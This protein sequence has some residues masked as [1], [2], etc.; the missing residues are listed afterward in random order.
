[1]EWTSF[2]TYGDAPADAFENFCNHLF[3]NYIYRNHPK[4]SKFR[5]VNG[6]GGD[7]GVEAYAQLT[8]GNISAVQSKWFPN[9]FG[10]AQIRQIR[11][12]VRT[13][14]TVRPNITEY[15]VCIPRT[16][17]SLRVTGSG[18]SG[19]VQLTRSSEDQLLDA[20]DAELK[21]EYPNLEIS[22][23]VNELIEAEL[24]QED[25]AGL[26][27]F[28]FDREVISL[29]YLQSQ[30][31]R[32]K[33]GW[34]HNRYVPHLHAQGFI[35][36]GISILTYDKAFRKLFLELLKSYIRRLYKA[37]IGVDKVQKL[38]SNDVGLEDALRRCREEIMGAIE[39]ANHLAK[40]LEEGVL[41]TAAP[42]FE[43]PTLEGAI[44]ACEAITKAHG[45]DA[46][47]DFLRSAILNL[48]YGDFDREHKL[49]NRAISDKGLLVLCG[50]GTGKTH[51]L[52]F[53][54][55]QH[56]RDQA[57]A[58][59]MQAFG[60]PC[61]SWAEIL[62]SGLELSGWNIDEILTALM[63][64]AT[65]C[66]RSKVNN[67]MTFAQEL[68]EAP[69][70]VLIVVDGLEE[71]LGNWKKWNERI[72]E[73]ILLATKYPRLKFL[74]SARPYFYKLEELPNSL[75]LTIYELP[76]QGDVPLHELALKYFKPENYN[77]TLTSP[78]LVRGLDSAFA[79]RLFCEQ[80]RDRNLS[81]ADHIKTAGTDLLTVKIN[82]MEIEFA[83]LLGRE[84]EEARTPIKKG[85]IVLANQ[86]F[87]KVKIDHDALGTVLQPELSYLTV[88]EIDRL[89]YY[90]SHNG[91]LVKDVTYSEEDGI[92]IPKTEYFV[93]YRSIIEII[94]ATR[95]IN[96]I[97]KDDLK[98]LPP[99]LFDRL[100]LG[101]TKEES[102]SNERIAQIIV[103]TMFH[104]H[105][106]L[107]GDGEYL[108]K[109]FQSHFVRKLRRESLRKAPRALAMKYKSE[110]D[111]QFWESHD[112]RYEL[113]L[114]QILPAS[115]QSENNFGA[116]YLHDIM[117]AFTSAYERDKIWIG[118]D[119]FGYPQ[120][121]SCDMSLEQVIESHNKDF[122]LSEYALHDETPLIYAWCLSSL[123]QRF[124][125]RIR[126]A[127]TRWALSM[128][129]EFVLLL[130]LVF[131]CN[132]P[133]IQEDLAAIS[134]ALAARL[135]KEKA[136]S[137]L[138][139]WAL[140]NVFADLRAHRNVIVRQ[141][142]RA[143]VERAYQYQLIND[144]YLVKCRPY[145]QKVIELLPMEVGSEGDEDNVFNPIQGDLDWYV[146][147]KATS[148]FLKV[149][150]GMEGQ[151][152]SQDN[153]A[154]E[155]LLDM[156]AEHYG[157][158]VFVTRWQMSAA[159]AYI[160]S[161]GFND[162]DSS[163][164]TEE[165]HGTKSKFFTYPEKYT[166][167]AVH[168][169]MGY[170][171]DYLPFSKGGD[172]TFIKDYSILVNLPNPADDL[173]IVA[174]LPETF[175][176][177]VQVESIFN[178]VGSSPYE[179]IETEVNREPE[180]DFSKWIYFSET[181]FFLGSSENQLIALY[182][183]T[184]INDNSGF[185]YGRMEVVGCLIPKGK[186]D[187]IIEQLQNQEYDMHFVENLDNLH[188]SPNTDIYSN[189]S[190][191][192]WMNWIDER[193]NSEQVFAAGQE[194]DLLFTITEV[195]R[196]G[197]IGEQYM[198]MPS[199]IVRNITA[200]VE[201]QGAFLLDKQGNI[202][203]FM[204]KIPF[205]DRESQEIV[206]VNKNVLNEA[207][208]DNGLELV[209]FA[210]CFKAKEVSIPDSNDVPHFQKC[211]K[212]IVY[213]AEGKVRSL[214][215]WDERFSNSR[216]RVDGDR[217]ES[218]ESEIK[219]YD[220]FKKDEIAQ[221]ENLIIAGGEVNPKTLSERLK[222][223]QAIAVFRDEAT[224]VATAAIKKPLASY[225]TGV[226]T[227]AQVETLVNEYS[228]ELGYVFTLLEYRGFKLAS[229]LCSQ[230]VDKFREF[231][232]FST[233]RI[234]NKAMFSTL[235][236]LG[237]IITGETFEN[238]DGTDN[239]FLYLREPEKHDSKVTVEI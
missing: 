170:L 81:G 223:V 130:D 58:L 156:Y 65:R 16:L 33:V 213:E 108:S 6:K 84:V 127:L 187:Y 10:P 224:I 198:K 209:W 161:L 155:H 122:Y 66:E 54:V 221:I 202:N 71:D 233:S 91:I 64:L 165:T 61:G 134:L 103:N 172:S 72:R 239:L 146:I 97:I 34:L 229:T 112:S 120:N 117:I 238:K 124:R 138:A 234:G 174:E 137:Q 151:L 1:M 235:S 226:F 35:H 39:R 143:I 102:L 11:N 18:E 135:K 104:E 82:K 26:H 126:K 68:R 27:R 154:A 153:P 176:H 145:K 40:D 206:S 30:F 225:K 83:V 232:L 125:D 2:K 136:I 140:K 13:A 113:L 193:P 188:A 28:W 142:F 160:R 43:L 222:E 204:H 69:T 199:K 29:S 194:F 141:G 52:A 212:Y 25:N 21:Q 50:P 85:L 205:V 93:T 164:S 5:V 189:P 46:Y 99:I 60:T 177:W 132:D 41:L 67:T 149:P 36:E 180:I 219:K 147:G 73:S 190:D 171:S 123:D 110:V 4:V 92:P 22:W 196:V 62:S 76:Q 31:D 17:T 169:L 63:S 210:E 200:I 3:R 195:T 237:F 106:K 207:L 70:S 79:L 7:G 214:K 192:V 186:T 163:S 183:S 227:K 42:S 181:D 191:L 139:D 215:F 100:I 178:T 94:L 133:Q 231:P 208:A 173:E 59:I 115:E 220:E 129:Y 44:K 121:I 19:E 78:S 89:L 51:G 37:T 131:P 179:L 166:W 148:G 80:Y 12:S 49:L 95:T 152:K 201:M 23:W 57:P 217:I 167:L 75:P 118:R 185:V 182:N 150:L 45:Q 175:D 101:A 55:E 38:I 86:F 87:V 203:A 88:N 9:D 162:K 158:R 74:Y 77:I 144:E 230:L 47:V 159:L 15:V 90:L 114:H 197:V 56:L 8:G 236:R 168:Y 211:R 105:G 228:L 216:D 20:L 14:L 157:E 53:T 32:Q 109:G 24:T 116:R 111:N 107:I 128:P 119:A 98:E 184:S 96:A 48:Y 218:L